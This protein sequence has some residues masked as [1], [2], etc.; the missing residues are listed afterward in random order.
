MINP[1]KLLYLKIWVPLFGRMLSI[2]IPMIEGKQPSKKPTYRLEEKSSNHKP[3]L[4]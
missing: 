1:L 2:F 4:Q 3:P